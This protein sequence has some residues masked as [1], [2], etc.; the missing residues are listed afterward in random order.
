MTYYISPFSEFQVIF[1][2][3][4]KYSYVYRKVVISLDIYA[5]KIKPLFDKTGLSDSELEKAIGLPRS[6]IYKWNNG[7][8]KS[9]KKYFAEISAYFNL[10]M[11]YFSEKEQKNKPITSKEDDELINLFEQ[12]PTDKKQEAVNYLRY[13]IEHRE[14]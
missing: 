2:F 11:D 12:I 4:V 13:L 1:R 8:N 7:V 9:Y 10:S 6:I 14:K 5:K 3:L